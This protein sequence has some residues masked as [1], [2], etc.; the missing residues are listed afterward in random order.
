[1]RLGI[2]RVRKK[3]IILRRLPVPINTVGRGQR[4]KVYRRDDMAKVSK[5]EL[6]WRKKQKRGAIMKPSTFK[7]IAKESPGGEKAAGSAYWKSVHKKY[8]ESR[9][10][11]ER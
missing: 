10:I 7:K 1:V 2:L 8:K 6:T 3:G 5:K 4:N 9:G 11:P